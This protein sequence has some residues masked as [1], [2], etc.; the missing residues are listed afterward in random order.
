MDYQEKLI[1]KY[2]GEALVHDPDE[3]YEWNDCELW[4]DNNDDDLTI[5]RNCNDCGG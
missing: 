2:G 5:Y 1:S 3:P 4:E